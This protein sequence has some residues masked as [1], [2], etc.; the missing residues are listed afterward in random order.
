[1]R[2]HP[3]GEVLVSA[4]Y[5]DSMKLWVGEDDEWVCA[6]TLSG[7]GVVDGRA[8]RRTVHTPAHQYQP[9]AAPCLPT[10]HV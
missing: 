5:D 4:S 6:Q 7:A 8:L 3:G 1:M 10:P 2:W 9:A